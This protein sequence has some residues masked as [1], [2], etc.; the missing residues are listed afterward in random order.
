MVISV[1]RRCD[2]PR[3]SFGWFLERLD[4]GFVDVPNPFN[5]ARVRRVFLRPRAGDG[6]AAFCFVFWTRDPGPLLRHFDALE[7]RGCR[8][9]VMVTLT[10]YPAILEPN[11]PAKDRVIHDMRMLAQKAGAAR[12]LWRYDPVFLSEQT[13]FSFHRENFAALARGLA[14]AVNRVIISVYDEYGGAKRR[15]A[16][17]EKGGACHALPHYD[18]EGRL[19]PELREVLSGFGRIAGEAGMEIQSC[20]EAEDLSALGIRPGPC[21]DGGRIEGLW[22]IGAKGKDKNQRPHCLCASS[23]DIG[24]YGPCPAGCV[25]CYARR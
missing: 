14:G 2:I 16:E 1:S 9:Y 5:A 12:V 21:V 19:R 18:D 15:L 6:G 20:A 23:V 10:G 8:F 4:E 22:G 25:Y 11:A 3:F 24:R 17:L 13:G 7:E